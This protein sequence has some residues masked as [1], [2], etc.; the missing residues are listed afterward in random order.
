MQNS[1]GSPR[2][3][4]DGK[5]G[6]CLHFGPGG[7]TPGYLQLPDNVFFLVSNAVS[8]DYTFSA[9]IRPAGNLQLDTLLRVGNAPSS[10]DNDVAFALNVTHARNIFL[11]S[12][13]QAA[14]AD[15]ACYGPSFFAS[16]LGGNTGEWIP[17]AVAFDSE[18]NTLSIY[19]PRGA[20]GI[21]GNV[22]QWDIVSKGNGTDGTQYGSV[23]GSP[24]SPEFLGSI[25]DFRIYNQ[26]VDPLTM[27]WLMNYPYVGDLPNVTVAPTPIPQTLPVGSV[28]LK[29]IG[30][31]APIA[32]SGDVSISGSLYLELNH[33]AQNSNDILMVQAQG[34]V[35]IG[36][37]TLFVDDI[38]VPN[39]SSQ[40]PLFAVISSVNGGR[41]RLTFPLMSHLLS[42][43]HWHLFSPGGT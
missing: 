24:F 33:N 17:V 5:F 32:S 7:T 11:Q 19:A 4:S 28:N 16:S 37:A 12:P 27:G 30:L 26:F 21:S 9:W 25:D 34:N 8:T 40:A 6:N 23:G 38:S 14:L 3:G 35:N 15:K 13:P 42:S 29:D 22:A 39:D 2:V 36:S 41:Q 20:G 1:R 18:D 10:C 31:H 43:H